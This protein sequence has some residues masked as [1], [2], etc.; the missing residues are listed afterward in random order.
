MGTLKL[1]LAIENEMYGKKEAKV[2][3]LDVGHMLLLPKL[4]L[5]S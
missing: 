4:D 3:S 2:A 5:I 1:M